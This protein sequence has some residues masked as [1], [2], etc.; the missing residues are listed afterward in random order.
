LKPEPIDADTLVFVNRVSPVTEFTRTSE[1][2]LMESS[3]KMYKKLFAAIMVAILVLS[4]ESVSVRKPR[5]YVY[6]VVIGISGTVIDRS[7]L[8]N[9][10]TT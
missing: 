6:K 10:C 3:P 7:F 8:A 1:K 9:P 4:V 5:T 2:T